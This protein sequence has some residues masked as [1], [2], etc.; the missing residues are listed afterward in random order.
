[1]SSFSPPSSIAAGGPLLPPA[2]EI[3]WPAIQPRPLRSAMLLRL[4]PAAA[5]DPLLLLALG[6]SRLRWALVVG[7]TPGASKRWR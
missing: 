7:T 3:M 4:L 6:R 2:R 5:A 1:M